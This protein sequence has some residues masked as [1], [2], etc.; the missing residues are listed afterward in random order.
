MLTCDA[1][2]GH[3][4]DSRRRR[5]ADIPDVWSVREI[6]LT[7]YLKS[8]AYRRSIRLGWSLLALVIKSKEPRSARVHRRRRPTAIVVPIARS[9]EVRIYKLADFR[10]RGFASRG[11]GLPKSPSLSLYINLRDE[12]MIQE[13]IEMIRRRSLHLH[14]RLR[15]R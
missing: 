6:I 4:V 13:S 7:A 3:G 10:A 2:G 12:S 11:L 1:R 15:R 5:Q 9:G 14:L 8:A